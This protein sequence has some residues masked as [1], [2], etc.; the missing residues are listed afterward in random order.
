MK[1]ILRNAVATAAVAAM[2][3]LCACGAQNDGSSNA[4]SSGNADFGDLFASF[5]AEDLNGDAQTQ[6]LVLKNRLTL[7]EVWGTYCTSCKA[8]IGD[9]EKVYE[10]YRGKGVG[11][12]GI[13]VDLTDEEG[14][15]DDQK[16]AAAR[17]IADD[18]GI[19][20]TNISVPGEVAPALQSISVI[21]SYFLLNDK[22]EAVSPVYDATKSVSEW[23]EI[24]DKKLGN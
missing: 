15:I 4:G 21:P 18:K 8:T 24:I 5:N 11:V 14:N 6:E 23:S 2:I 9:T 19:K 1:R 22:G 16:V 3:L 20:F 12:I 7:V 13:V 17:K 10:K